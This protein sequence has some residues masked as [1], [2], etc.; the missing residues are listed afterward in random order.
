[1]APH[2]A[3]VVSVHHSCIFHRRSRGDRIGSI[4]SR[5]KS[6]FS[7]L[8]RPSFPPVSIG[9]LR[10]EIRNK[11]EV[12]TPYPSPGGTGAAVLW[13]GSRLSDDFVY[14]TIYSSTMA[15]TMSMAKAPVAAAR[16]ARVTRVANKRSG[17]VEASDAR[18]QGDPTSRTWEE[19]RERTTGKRTWDE[20]SARRNAVERVCTNDTCVEAGVVHTETA[21]ERNR[22]ART[23]V[24]TGWACVEGMATVEKEV[25]GPQNFCCNR[26]SSVL[27]V[28]VISA[29]IVS[30]GNIRISR[31]T[32]KPCACLDVAPL[33]RITEWLLLHL[34]SHK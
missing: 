6:P 23:N 12:G 11:P 31:C 9:S 21:K 33:R 17:C 16:V 14:R 29:K 34:C 27:T 3:W 28:L 4:H 25:E 26:V 32:A 30:G 8:F 2:P 7:S 15:T 24:T 5:W 20:G 22:G 18:R 13:S 10:V 19:A 1:M